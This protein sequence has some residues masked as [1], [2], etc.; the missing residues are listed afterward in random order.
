MP[1]LASFQTAGRASSAF[2]AARGGF[3]MMTTIITMT[4]LRGASG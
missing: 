1:T 3:G 2:A 4:T